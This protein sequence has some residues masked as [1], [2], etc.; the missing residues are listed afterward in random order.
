[1]S[2]WN[3]EHGTMSTR[4]DE[5]ENDEHENDEHREVKRK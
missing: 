1:M 2:T 3:D 5:H 4:N